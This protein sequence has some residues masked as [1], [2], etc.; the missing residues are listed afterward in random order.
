MELQ[1]LLQEVDKVMRDYSK[2]HMFGFFN[3][4][5]FQLLF[6]PSISIQ[7]LYCC[8]LCQFRSL[9]MDLSRIS[10]TWESPRALSPSETNWSIWR[11]ECS[12]NALQCTHTMSMKTTVYRLV[13]PLDFVAKDLFN[14][15]QFFYMKFCN[16]WPTT[17]V[18]ICICY[19]LKFTFQEKPKMFCHECKPLTRECF[20]KHEIGVYW[21]SSTTGGKLNRM[22]FGTLNFVCKSLLFFWLKTNTA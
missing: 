9:I 5:H 6:C 2:V 8:F 16:C 4:D 3:F 13:L 21:I 10:P 1:E 20:L 14:G 7:M 17:C 18:C 12:H 11:S 15:P 19:I 22:E